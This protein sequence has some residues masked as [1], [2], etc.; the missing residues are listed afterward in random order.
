MEVKKYTPE[1]VLDYL[2]KNRKK[3]NKYF[4]N[5]MKDIDKYR[6]FHTDKKYSKIYKDEDGK[7]KI[8]CS[9]LTKENINYIV[10]QHL[11]ISFSPWDISNKK[12]LEYYKQYSRTHKNGWTISGQIVE[13]YVSWVP[14]IT[15][16]HKNYGIIYGDFSEEI[17]VVSDNPDKALFH[18]LDNN[19]PLVWKFLILLCK[20]KNYINNKF[21]K[22]IYYGQV[23]IYN[24][25]NNYNNNKFA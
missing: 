3:Y 1:F 11:D 9:D 8:C 18:F 24:Q 15:A 14:F 25:I 17:I 7:I 5:K 2:Y 10:S 23:G 20:I 4:Q 13:D 12:K 21:T 22:Q 6:I 16:S 19:M